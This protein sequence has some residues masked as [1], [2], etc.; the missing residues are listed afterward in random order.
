MCYQNEVIV[1]VDTNVFVSAVMSANGA[2]RQVIRLCL[3]GKL[4]PLMGN[5]LFSEYEDVCARDELFDARLISRRDR[6]A[7][8]DA[9]FA[10]CAWVPIYF[11]W[12]PN[13]RDE[14]D[15]H[16]VELAVAGGAEMI[17]TA[18][19]RDFRNAELSFPSIEICN[20]IEFLQ[21][22]LFAI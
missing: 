14:A 7:L 19:K 22:G 17:I 21:K 16:V 8:L 12:R 3:Q 4:R 11:L 1:V 10:S 20:S 5:A 2:S 9:F 18:N 6:D 15:N 13:L